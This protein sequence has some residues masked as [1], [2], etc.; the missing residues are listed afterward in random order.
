MLNFEEEK[1]PHSAPKALRYTRKSVMR[2][3]RAAAATARW[4]G[5]KIHLRFEG[6]SVA[7]H[8]E[9]EGDGKK[10]RRAGLK[11]TD[12]EIA[13]EAPISTNSTTGGKGEKKEKPNKYSSAAR[14]KTKLGERI[15]LNLGHDA[16]DAITEQADASEN[17]AVRAADRERKI[18]GVG[19]KYGGRVGKWHRSGRD[20]RIARREGKLA[21]NELKREHKSRQHFERYG[22]ELP[23]EFRR[24]QR[25]Q[26]RQQKR[27]QI[28]SF[29]DAK[30]GKGRVDIAVKVMRF[31]AGTVK[32]AMF[33]VI[34]YLGFPLLGVVVIIALLF[35]M[36][37]MLFSFLQGGAV[38]ILSSYTSPDDAIEAAT[39]LATQ[40]E[41]KLE[42]EIESIPSQW[43]WEHIDEFRYYTDEIG[44]DPFELMAYLSVTHP[45]FEMDFASPVPRAISDLHEKRYNLRLEEDKETRTRPEPSIDPV[46]GEIVINSVA[47]TYYILE[48]YLTSRSIESAVREELQSSDGELWEWYGVL[49]G[50]GGARQ[51]FA[52]PFPGVD[53]RDRVTSL[54]GWRLSPVTDRKTLQ[55]HRGLD[56]AMLRGTSIHAGLD[57]YVYWVGADDTFGNYV[58]LASDTTLLKYAH[59]DTITAVQGQKVTKGEV[60]ATV[61]NTGISTGSHLHIEAQ[62]VP[63]E[64]YLNPIFLLNYEEETENEE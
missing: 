42:Q 54:Y 60:I 7:K 2:G 9:V 37:A 38:I 34:S 31:L 56:I 49:M 62:R 57:G 22:D 52:N 11:F 39:L 46:T 15:L 27:K 25:Q 16:S 23:S 29:A 33:T 35:G 64:S 5:K 41:A 26:K 8:G 17:D 10:S 32:K 20:G 50:T 47:Y 59:C 61:G 13:A 3:S 43:K 51:E 28:R 6:D 21:A 58:I 19:A 55:T 14:G 1:T 30:L 36:A 63:G 45:G 48:V 44:H 18:V 40:L 4:A 24:Q 12:A 53:W